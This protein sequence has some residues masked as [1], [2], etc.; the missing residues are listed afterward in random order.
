MI[1]EYDYLAKG[2]WGPGAS[3]QLD[4]LGVRWLISDKPFAG[5]P[6]VAAVPGY[7]VYERPSSLSAF[8]TFDPKTGTRAR[9]PVEAVEWG[10]NA[11]TVKLCTIAAG[12]ELVFAQPSFP[13][14]VA[15][16][17]GKK[18]QLGEQEIFS[19]LPVTGPM[20]DVTFS[21]RPQLWPW[22]G[23]SLAGCLVAGLAALSWAFPYRMATVAARASAW[24]RRSGLAYLMR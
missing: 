6:L 13:G 14:W 3:D 16:V 18:V 15:F 4:R 1:S 21:Y 22:V 20:H 11:V 24:S 2:S 8:W 9:A 7:Y 19:A 12:E 17:D 23:T 5:L 10:E